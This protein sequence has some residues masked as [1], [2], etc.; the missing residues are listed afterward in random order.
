VTVKYLHN[1]LVV[2]AIT[3]LLL[4]CVGSVDSREI[5][6]EDLLEQIIVAYGGEENLRKLNNHI[7]EWDV[8]ALVGKRHGTDTRRIRVPDQ[9]K[10]EVTYPHRKETRVVNGESGYFIFRGAPARMATQP[11]KDAMRL[12]LMRHYSPLLL[13]EKLD[14]LILAKQGK[15][16][17]ITL[18]EHG[19]RVDYFV[20]TENWHIE[21]VVGSLA[22]N[23]S[24]M[25][26]LT[27]YSN[28]AFRDGVLVHL[29]ENKFAGGV[30]TAILQ[31]RRITLDAELTEAD[32]LPDDNK[33]T[34]PAQDQ[35]D[36]I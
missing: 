28:F 26:F 21:K 36:I 18:F 32:F 27:E 25:Q 23:G 4:A 29:K 6:L 8:V 35:N 5:D 1:R 14:S 22:I 13:R 20:N 33:L 11:Q 2:L 7:Q 10:V 17:V 9:L 15:F 3:C 24:G 19:V 12:Q 34:P 31:L 30:N 16:R